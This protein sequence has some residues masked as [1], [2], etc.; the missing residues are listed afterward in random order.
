VKKTTTCN[1]WRT[2][3]VW[4]DQ[5]VQV[6]NLHMSPK[7]QNFECGDVTERKE[8]RRKMGCKSFDWFIE[9]VYPELQVRRK[10]VF[11]LLSTK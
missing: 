9:N 11:S 6:F 4:L 2:A 3:A 10:R 7:E 1:V 8:M 5:Y